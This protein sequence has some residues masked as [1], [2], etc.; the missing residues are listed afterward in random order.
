MPIAPLTT[1]SG[2]PV[3]AEVTAR[4]SRACFR[5]PGYPGGYHVV[6]VGVRFAS[7]PELAKVI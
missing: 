2:E 3:A 5:D 4:K 1:T 7:F 6:I